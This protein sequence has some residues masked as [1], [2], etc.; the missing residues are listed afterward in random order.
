[1][2]ALRSVICAG[3]AHVVTAAVEGSTVMTSVM[4]GNAGDT[5]IVVIDSWVTVMMWV[6]TSVAVL[7]ATTDDEGNIPEADK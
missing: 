5:V 6:K 3:A 1:L 4:V 2:K 7:V